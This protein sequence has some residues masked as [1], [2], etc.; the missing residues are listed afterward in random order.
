MRTP[1]VLRPWRAGRP[2]VNIAL[3]MDQNSSLRGRTICLV[4][5]MGV[6]KSSIGRRLAQALDLPF[7]DADEEIERAAGRTVPEIFAERGEEE[8]RAGE[9]RVIARLLDEPPLVLATGGGAFMNAETRRL[10]KE[11]AVSVWLRADLDVL[12]RRV[13]KRDNRP[14]LKGRNPREALGE[15]MRV[16]DP[17]YAEADIAVETGDGPHQAALDAIL[18]ALRARLEG[19]A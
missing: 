19:A 6:G 9:R 7:R 10:I 5:M 16:R 17:V 4:G 14:L 1:K 12:V 3:S 13:G 8:F 2:S 18:G 11:K 15:L